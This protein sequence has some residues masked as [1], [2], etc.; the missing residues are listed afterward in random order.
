MTQ[1]VLRPFSPD[2]LEWLVNVH[3]TLYAR[4][5]GFDA[6]FGVLVRQVL[7]AFL[8]TQDPSCEAGWIAERSGH[9]LGSIFCV[10][11]DRE[12][13]QLRLFLA[14]PEMRGTGLGRRLL[15]R[16]MGFAQRA[17]YAGML[18]W[19]HESHVAACAL[20]RKTGWVCEGSRPVRSFG[21]DLVEQ[22]WRFRF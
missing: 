18:L 10:R 2:D 4:D 14:L 20:Y 17:G 16:C 19:T 12:L 22:S 21:V 3:Q 6:S 15:G 9:R 13:A 7:Q 1:T 8:A 5:E 11:L